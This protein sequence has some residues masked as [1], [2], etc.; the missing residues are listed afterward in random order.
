M[1]LKLPKFKKR[2]NNEAKYK[3]QLQAL[4]ELINDEGICAAGYKTLDQD[5]TIMTA[6]EAVARLVGLV[7]WHL[8]QN[9]DEGDKRIK[10]ELSRKIDIDPNSYMVRQNFYEAIALNLLLYGDGNCVVRPHTENGF[11]KDLEII[12]ASRVSFVDDPQSYGY[13]I[14][15]DGVRYDPRDLIHFRLSSDKRYPWLGRG[16]RVSI[17][18]IADNLQQAAVTEKAFMSKKYKPSVIVN[19]QAM[20]EEF[21]SSEGRRSIVKDYLETSEAGEPWVIPA[22]QMSVSQVKPLTL[23]DLAIADTVKLNKA[24]A[25][26]IVGVPAFLVG[27]GTFNKDEFNNFVTTRVREVVENIQQTMTKALIL[28]DRWYVRVTSG[29]FLIGI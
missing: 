1:A 27:I 15:I 23:Q 3:A 29:R 16:V 12:S 7:S 22:E 13:W 19:V 6:C 17:K 24:T 18:D 5:P 28:S 8:M 26:S 11:L 21:Q 14:Y 25:A 4:M 20:G 2:S 10:N 9:T